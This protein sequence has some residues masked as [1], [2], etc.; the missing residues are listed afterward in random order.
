[1]I[2]SNVT[3][4]DKNSKYFLNWRQVK[5]GASLSFLG[6]GI[7]QILDALPFYVMLIDKNHRI[8]LANKATR[9]ALGL[10]PHDIV[11]EYCPRVVH[12]I[13][14]G[15]YPGCPL[16]KAVEKGSGVEQEFYDEKE[17]RWLRVAIYPTGTWSVDGQ[18]IYFHMAQ[19]ITEQ[20][21]E[22]EALKQAKENYRKLYEKSKKR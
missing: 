8:L 20:K 16:E 17:G 7:L 22:M 12:G 2:L 9:E 1:M 10:E 19:D 11:G 5:K 3:A 15:A 4:D 18:E 21:Q 14:E 13:E 6:P